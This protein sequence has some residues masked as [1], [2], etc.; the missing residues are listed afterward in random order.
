[1]PSLERSVSRELRG[2][3]NYTSL[4]SGYLKLAI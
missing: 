3:L 4:H 2:S 1:M